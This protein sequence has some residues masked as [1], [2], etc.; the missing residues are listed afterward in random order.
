MVR[1]LVVLLL[2]LGTFARAANSLDPTWARVQLLFPE[3]D[4]LGAKEGQPPAAPVYAGDRVVGY[5]ALTNDVT[6]I[7]AY[8][9]KPINS[10]VGVDLAGKVRG[11]A[12]VEHEEP[13]LKVGISKQRLARYTAQYAGLQVG[14]D[15]KVGGTPG[16]GQPVIDGISGATITVM[17]INH[18]FAKTVAQVAAAR[19][20]GS[21]AAAVAVAP[22]DAEPLW[23]SLW[24]DRP[25]RIG[26]LSAGLGVLLL[27]LLF[28]D[29][30]A[31]HPTLLRRVRTGFLLYTVGYL[32]W[33]GLGQLSVV[34]VL[35]FVHALMHGFSWDGFLMEPMLF[36]LWSFVAFTVLL[37]GRGVYCGWL[38]PFG[39]LQELLFRVGRACR[40][41]EWEP[42]LLLHE[43]LWALKYVLLIALFGLSLQSLGRAETFAE[44][45]PFKTVFALHFLREW[46]FVAYVAGVL[47]AGL[48]VR[49]AFCRYLCPLGAAL[50]FPGRFRIF[51]WLRRRRECGRP[52]QICARKCEVGAIRPT[53]EIID[54]ECHYCL[55]CQVT[56]WDP[57]KCPPL[58]ERRKKAE[59]RERIA[60]AK[61]GRAP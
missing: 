10:L 31:R 27:I 26:V 40:A 39:A 61:A 48:V 50:T 9:G 19:G 16:P 54:N 8:S 4:R 44:V 23:V 58:I 57:H 30:L 46:P 32:G 42:P 5:V 14:D 13:I 15:V 22:A 7:P 52:C 41:P 21:L 33:Y 12:I 55:D 49:K 17:V 60:D 43:R 36:L 20:I 18:T 47:A 3:A 28:Q 2:V 53:G 24:R 59:A 37:W 25:W 6:R 35:T 1:Y 38:C 29:W 51:E 11:V 56:Y 34:H 45:E